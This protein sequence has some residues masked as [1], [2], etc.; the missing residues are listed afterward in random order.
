MKRIQ[1]GVPEKGFSVAE[2][3]DVQTRSEPLTCV[4]SLIWNQWLS[5]E[6]AGMVQESPAAKMP[7]TLDSMFLDQ[8]QNAGDTQR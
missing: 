4:H 5:G 7:G 1:E 2:L 6:G 8:H 3:A